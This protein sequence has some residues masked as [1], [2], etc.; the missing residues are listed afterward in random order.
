MKTLL[1]TGLLLAAVAAEG[2][3]ATDE[4][5]PAARDVAAGYFT[6]IFQGDLDG[7]MAVVAAP[8]SFDRKEVLKS[9]DEVR[10]KHAQIVGKKGKRKVP[11]Y[12]IALTDGAPALDRN[13]FPAYEVWRITIAGRK[14]SIDIYVSKGET[15]RV[16]GLSD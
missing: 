10:Q 2:W 13:V 1:T 14:E 8:F 6:A 11:E 5:Q 9:K 4:K 12:T 16:I 7:I 3:A 15:P